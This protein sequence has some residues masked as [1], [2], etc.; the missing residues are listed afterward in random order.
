MTRSTIL[1]MGN[2]DVMVALTA[3]SEMFASEGVVYRSNPLNGPDRR[4]MGGAGVAPDNN[5]GL[6][7]V[8]HSRRPAH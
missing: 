7:E 1:Q 8:R 3:N 2:G 6:S 4:P 5:L